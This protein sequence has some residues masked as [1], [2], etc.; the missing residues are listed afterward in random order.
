[1]TPRKL[2]RWA[3]V[4][5]AAVIASCTDSPEQPSQRGLPISLLVFSGNNQIGTA[6]QELPQPIKV[7]A[8]NSN[9]QPIAGQVVN[10]VVTTGGGSVF[11]GTALTDA[12]GIAAEVWRVGTV[13]GSV[14]TVEVR[15][16]APDGTKQVFGVFTASVIAAAPDTIVVNG[17]NGQSAP[18]NAAVPVAPSVRVADQY[19]NPVINQ[20]VTFSV[21]GGG[22]SVTGSPA[23]T[24]S[25]GIATVGS[26]ILGPN[27]G[28]N[29]MNA[30]VSGLPAVGFNA[31]G[32]AVAV[33]Q[34]AITTQPP[35]SAQS[36]VVLSPAPVIQLQDNQGQ[37]LHQANVQV[38]A[39]INSG[40]GSVGGTTT[41]ATDGNGVATF[42]D[43]SISGLVGARTLAFNASGVTG[44]TSNTINLAAGPAAS[45]VVNDGN[46]QSANAGT[47]LAVAP[48]VLLTDASGNPVSGVVVTF[49]VA[50]GGGVLTGAAPTSDGF[51][52]ARVGSWTLGPT[53]GSNSVTATAT[54]SGISGN[55][56]SFTATALGNFWSARASMPT[57]RRFTATGVINGLLYVAGGKDA[58]LTTVKTL[59]IYN[60]AT[61]TW[62]TG[63]AMNTARVGAQ[64]GVINGI[65]YVAGGTNPS[66]VILS[67]VESYNPATNTWTN[68][69]AMPIARNFG[70]SA[71]VD[72]I[73]YIAAGGVSG[74]QT[75]SV[76]AYN[77]A[78]NSWST[79]ASLPAARNDAVGVSLNDL[80][81]VI[82]G[83]QGNSNDGALQVYDPL[84]DSWSQ[85]ATMLTPRYHANA[86]VINGLLYVAGGLVTG[87]ATSAVTEVY[88]PISNGWTGR[89]GL[90][91]PR[92]G[93][94]TGAIGGILYLSGGSANGGVLGNN[95]AYVP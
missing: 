42:S 66:N 76:V 52:I 79:K 33:P 29:T 36:G 55:P 77:P 89:A 37:P 65:L 69:A 31:T 11:A 58:S 9:N 92:S 82:G 8:T 59:E 43:L 32:Q 87:G 35:A 27:P 13:A 22:G 30:T 60:P 71:V 47:Q 20:P 24:N 64:Y 73:L 40:G 81:Y 84:T 70:A 85:A 62:T 17:G 15:A 21:T 56:V 7:L 68:R 6:G 38:T 41:V 67:T 90:I 86:E 16:V 39:T 3:L 14:Q 80:F 53:S 83:Q 61:N 50:S 48:S 34:L 95:E 18:V 26:W 5:F 45:I 49:A 4:A 88:D 72:G 25:S 74:G 23:N 91:T 93:A 44:I 94:A 12:N 51:G 54:G 57:P 75:A 28:P 1:M 78:T 46:G 63:K 19:G 10:F 2:G